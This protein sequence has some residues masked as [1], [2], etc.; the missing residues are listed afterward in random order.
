[1]AFKRGT[2]VAEIEE[3]IEQLENELAQIKVAI[4]EILVQLEVLALRDHNPL[5]DPTPAHH[6]LAHDT[7]IIVVSS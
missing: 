5:A 4:K 7:P 3:R 2:S 6:S 1:M